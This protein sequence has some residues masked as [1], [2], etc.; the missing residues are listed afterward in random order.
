MKHAGANALDRLESLLAKLR[1]LPG[2]KEKKRGVFYWKNRAFLHFHDDPKGI[3]AD[4]RDDTGDDFGRFDLTKAEDHLEF[5]D[6]VAARL[7]DAR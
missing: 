6:A 1:T 2:V 5:F 4:L 7:I 3:F